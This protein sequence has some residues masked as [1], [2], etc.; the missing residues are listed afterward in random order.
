MYNHCL[1]IVNQDIFWFLITNNRSHFFSSLFQIFFF[2]F[3]VQDY[4]ELSECCLNHMT[5]KHFGPL[6]SQFSPK[7]LCLDLNRKILNITQDPS[8]CTAPVVWN[9]V[10]ASCLLSGRSHISHRD[11]WGTTISP[12]HLEVLLMSCEWTKADGFCIA[13]YLF[14]VSFKVYSMFS[15][16]RPFKSLCPVRQEVPVP[17]SCESGHKLHEILLRQIHFQ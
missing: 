11:S 15:P 12:P 17:R 16:M 4:L 14:D 7:W 10:Y 8:L 6:L 2:K 1:N 3:P 13:W 9:S 5:L